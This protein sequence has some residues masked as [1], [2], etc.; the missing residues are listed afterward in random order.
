MVVPREPEAIAG[1]ARRIVQRTDDAGF[2]QGVVVFDEQHI[3]HQPDDFAGSKMF[4]GGFVGEFSKLAD[5]FFKDVPHLLVG[6]HFRM[7]VDACKLLSDHVQQVGFVES[8]HLGVEVKAFK[9]VP[10]S[11]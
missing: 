7:Q 2:G 8:L 10:H 4:S 11:R 9:D 6:D 1:S 5:Q 3:D